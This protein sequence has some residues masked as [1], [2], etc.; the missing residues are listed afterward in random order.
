MRPVQR[1]EILD[2][3]TWSERRAA[4]LPKVLEIKRRRR[5]HLGESLTFL[6]ENTDTVRYQIQEMVRVERMVRESEIQ[7]ELATYN[8]L[9]GGE[10]EL[11]CTMLIEIEDPA[12]RAAK[13]AEWID[14]PAHIYLD[15]ADGRRVYAQFD[16]RQRGEHKLSSVQFLRFQTDGQV[17]VAIGSELPALQLEAKLTDEQREALQQDLG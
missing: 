14:L 9:L 11:T 15:L 1:D 12:E 7:H 6:F 13:L 10:G 4:E 3:V 5:V 8:E 17:P 16:A 2:Y